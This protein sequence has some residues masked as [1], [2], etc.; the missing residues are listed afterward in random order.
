VDPRAGLDDVENIKFL[1][2]QG[3]ELRPF[4]PPARS[5]SLYRN[6]ESRRS[7][8]LRNYADFTVWIFFVFFYRQISL[9][10]FHNSALNVTDW[11]GFCDLCRLE[12]LVY[13][14]IYICSYVVLLTNEHNMLQRKK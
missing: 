11:A 9:E 4:V 7:L 14:E 8:L 2:L 12:S 13:F 3:L 10:D 5:Q 1:T 6:K